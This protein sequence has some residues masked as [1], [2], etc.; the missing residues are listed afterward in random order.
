MK[1]NQKESEF[2]RKAE[3]KLK[4]AAGGSTDH[5]EV[6]SERMT[7]LIHELRVHQ[8]ELEL[9]NDE[10]RR[11]QGELEKTRDKYFHL[12]DFSPV[13]YVTLTEK[14]I[15]DESNLPLSSML[16]VERTTLI[17]KPFTR[18]VLGEDQD[19]F[20]KLRHRLL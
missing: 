9:Q 5:S 6:P 17:G 11:V 19:V 10:L 7:N 4:E 12:Y 2:R 8:I 1:G 3:E 18:F 20:Y 14:G 16:G 13:G 15:I